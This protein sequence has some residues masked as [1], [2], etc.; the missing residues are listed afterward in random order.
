MDCLVKL[1]RDMKKILIIQDMIRDYRKPVYNELS[2]YYDI[3]VLHTGKISVSNNDNYKERI[4]SVRKFGPFYLHSSVLSEI[5]TGQYDVVIAMFDIRWPANIIAVFSKSNTRFLYWGHRY[6]KN[7]PAN[8]F[9]DFLMRVSDGQILYSDQEITKIK[10]HG[11]PESKIFVAPNTMHIPNHSDG[12]DSNKNS[13][14]FVGRL[15]KR[16]KLDILLKAFDDI[17]DRLPKNTIIN[18]VGNG[19]EYDNLQTM[20]NSL[21]ISEQVIFHG[22]I[23]A[24]EKLKPLFHSAYAYV[25]PGPVGLGVLHSLAYGI[26]IVTRLNEYHGPEF[27]NMVD[28]ENSLIYNTYDQLKS[29]LVDLCTDKTLSKKLGK[30]AYDLYRQHRS[31]KNMVQGFREAIDNSHQG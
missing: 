19:T 10:S 2:K 5:K 8:R 16:K 26:P 4:T 21:N 28:R 13:F 11:L 9:R 30:N 24:D 17:R 27:S 23:L 7:W 6:S 3:T 25:S 31:L 15:Q 18:I 12:S 14:L 22:K 20:A 1:N 29:I